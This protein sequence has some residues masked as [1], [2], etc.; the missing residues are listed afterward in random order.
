MTARGYVVFDLFDGWTRPLDQA[1][2]LYDVAFIRHDSPLRG[3]HDFA[4]PDA[5]PSGAMG[6]VNALRARLGM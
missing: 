1:L 6:M 3:S 4:S 5:K 2:A